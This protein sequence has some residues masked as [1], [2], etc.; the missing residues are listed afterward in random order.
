MYV[1][2]PIISSTTPKQRFCA[3]RE[4]KGQKRSIAPSLQILSLQTVW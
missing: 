3:E 2:Q 4:T 1:K